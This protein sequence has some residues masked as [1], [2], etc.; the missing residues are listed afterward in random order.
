MRQPVGARL[1]G[2]VGTDDALVADGLVEL[3]GRVNLV[4]L[5][6]GE[7]RVRAAGG[8]AIVVEHG[9][10]FFGGAA[11]VAGKLDVLVA[12]LRNGGERAGEI[13]LALVA[14]GIEF[15]ADGDFF[16]GLFFRRTT[17]R[18]ATN[19]ATGEG[20]ASSANGSAGEEFTTVQFG[21]GVFVHVRV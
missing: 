12:H 3:D 6:I 1:A 13:G 5:E 10:D 2:H 7:L 4:G 8:E 9:A 14:H 16:H 20:E 21:G 11:P 18:G 15:E 17:C 19:H